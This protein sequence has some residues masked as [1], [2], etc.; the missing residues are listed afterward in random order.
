MAVKSGFDGGLSQPR[1][2][3][4]TDPPGAVKSG[5]LRPPGVGP[6]E[7]TPS[8]TS[9]VDVTVPRSLKPATLIVLRPMFATVGDPSTFSLLAAS[10][11]LRPKKAVVIS[12]LTLM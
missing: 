1:D 5:F 11:W 8:T 10:D 4:M 9:S 2:G 12:R 6:R 7:L 3:P